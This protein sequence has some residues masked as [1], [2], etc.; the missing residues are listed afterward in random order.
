MCSAGETSYDKASEN[1]SDTAD[2][3]HLFDFLCSSNRK[4]LPNNRGIYKKQVERISFIDE[5]PVSSYRRSS[6]LFD[7]YEYL[8]KDSAVAENK[9][10]ADWM[11]QQKKKI[12][13][14]LCIDMDSRG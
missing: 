7:L 14:K 13:H 11:Y 4:C 3:M 10:T 6:G 8:L 1:H 9:Y 2:M 12:L 5:V